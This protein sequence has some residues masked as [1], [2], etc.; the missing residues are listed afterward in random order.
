MTRSAEWATGKT[1]GAQN[2]FQ[3]VNNGEIGFVLF[4]LF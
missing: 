1:P 2:S 4:L 3:N